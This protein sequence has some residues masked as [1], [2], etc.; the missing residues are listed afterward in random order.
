MIRKQ[1]IRWVERTWK[2]LKAHFRAKESVGLKQFDQVLQ[3]WLY[4]YNM[5][6]AGMRFDQIVDTLVD[7]F[8]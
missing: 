4:R 5:E 6:R 7:C 1:R 2:P 3:A 8:H